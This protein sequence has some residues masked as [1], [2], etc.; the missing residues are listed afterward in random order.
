MVALATQREPTEILLLFD[1]TSQEGWPYSRDGI[2]A[3][4]DIGRILLERMD[5]L[6]GNLEYSLGYY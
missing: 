3:S 6:P 1:T 5:N 2:P 4:R